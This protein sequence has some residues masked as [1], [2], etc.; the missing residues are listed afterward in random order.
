MGMIMLLRFAVVC[1]YVALATMLGDPCHADNSRSIRLIGGYVSGAGNVWNYGG[2]PA[3][4]AALDEAIISFRQQ[5]GLPQHG[6]ERLNAYNVFPTWG[7]QRN[8][9]HN[10]GGILKGMAA[11]RVGRTMIPVVGVKLFWPKSD[12]AQSYGW[13]S[14]QA[15]KDVAAGV[16]DK[17]WSRM[18]E[19]CA[20]NGFS[21][22]MFRIAYEA[23]FDFMPDGETGDPA[24][25]ALWTAAVSHVMRVIRAE[26]RAKGVTVYL[27]INPALGNST[28]PVEATMPD[29]SLWDVFFVD[30][31][32]SFW[33]AG[34]VNDPSVRIAFWHN[35]NGFGLDQAAALAKKYHKPI[36]IAEC[37]AGPNPQGVKNGVGNDAAFWNMLG[38]W[39]QSLRQR[40]IGFWGLNA[41]NINPKDGT[42]KM[43]DGVQ[44]AALAAFAAN[45]RSGNFIGDEIMVSR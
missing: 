25:Q 23:N 22:A 16:Y 26:A 2:E 18:V 10:L 8:W 1:V 7:P 20:S 14:P 19:A 15:F 35:P 39:I 32:N 42:F 3:K 34:D 13:E 37:G 27:G 44:P 43:T 30:Q 21:T 5:I 33:G 29:P 31:Y 9:G 17:V 24:T 4:A 12:D 11:S 38:E 40:G 6:V 36:Y 41:W 28:H 45:V